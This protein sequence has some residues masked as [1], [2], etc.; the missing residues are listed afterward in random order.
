MKTAFL[1]PGQGVEIAQ[2][3]RE[4]YE[5]SN[6]VRALL[7]H[8][9][10]YVDVS[11][12]DLFYRGGREFSRTEV[13][14]PILT[15]I[16]LGV[17]D[18][19]YTK[20]INPAMV[21]GHSLGEIAAWSAA[22]CISFQD[23]VKLAA[24]R[25]ELMARQTAG[26][27]G[28]MVALVKCNQKTAEMAADVGLPFGLVEIAAYNAPDEWVLS[29]EEGA[30]KEILTSKKL[31]HENNFQCVRLNVSGPWHGSILKG[32]VK[33]FREELKKVP[34][35]PLRTSF[36]CNRYGSF[37]ENH[38]H[39]PDLLAEQLIHPVQWSQTHTTLYHSNVSVVVTIGPGKVLRSLIRK[40][41]GTNVKV[42]TTETMADLNRTME[43]FDNE[44]KR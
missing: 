25:G 29:G 16:S 23:A 4:L 11:L 6:R 39:I 43:V 40:N 33:E 14:Q 12:F 37:V 3:G 13:F 1:F 5:S 27:S 17:Y 35:S 28:G 10:S 15:A 32:A 8:A 19:L 36:V 26:I 42:Y 24:F 34:C 30:I 41:L 20:G 18:E 9:S 22:G 2:I 38:E 7:E 31:I 44:G 21:A